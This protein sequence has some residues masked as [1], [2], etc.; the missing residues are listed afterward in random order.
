MEAETRYTG[1]CCQYAFP[2][3]LQIAAAHCC[4]PNLVPTSSLVEGGPPLHSTSAARHPAGAMS[5]VLAACK[6]HEDST[7]GAEQEMGS[8]WGG[9]AVASSRLRVRRPSEYNDQGTAAPPLPQDD[10]V[11]ADQH[12]TAGTLPLPTL[13]PGQEGGTGEPAADDC[14]T[15]SEASLRIHISR[16]RDSSLGGGSEYSVASW[17]L[18]SASSRRSTIE[19]GMRSRGHSRHASLSEPPIALSP[20]ATSPT[21]GAQAGARRG[22]AD[23]HELWGGADVRLVP[24]PPPTVAVSDQAQVPDRLGSARSPPQAVCS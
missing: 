10:L 17:G 18:P 21:K 16:P 19:Q 4:V 14:D 2:C 6:R 12:A 23:W 24:A 1:A 20:P 22:T 9:A 11:G 5:A 15:C 7:E 3:M 13:E 8:A